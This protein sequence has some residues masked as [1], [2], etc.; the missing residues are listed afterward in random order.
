[1]IKK[2]ELYKQIKQYLIDNDMTNRR[3]LNIAKVSRDFGICYSVCY[4]YC[5][6]ILEELNKKDE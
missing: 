4:K 5:L 1:M 3:F 2:I 6:I